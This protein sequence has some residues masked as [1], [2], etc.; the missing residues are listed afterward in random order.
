MRLID[1]ERIAGEWVMVASS[2][3][4]G[5]NGDIHDLHTDLYVSDV[6]D[7]SNRCLVVE[8]GGWP[9]WADDRTVYFHRQAKDGW[10]SI[11]QL[12]FSHNVIT[13]GMLLL[14]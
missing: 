6:S 1:R 8:N 7:G 12:T 4:R 13:Q 9:T 3:G 10:W 14:S 2:Q 11:Y 5:W